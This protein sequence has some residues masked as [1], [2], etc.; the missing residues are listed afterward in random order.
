MHILLSILNLKL[1]AYSH[2][3]LIEIKTK[4]CNLIKHLIPLTLLSLIYYMDK[5]CACSHFTGKSTFNTVINKRSEMNTFPCIYS[6]N[7][8]ISR[9]EIL[10]YLF[11]SFIFKLFVFVAILCLQIQQFQI[12]CA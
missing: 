2:V 9:S 12:V 5:R 1:L 8:S 7:T 11:I 6:K 10:F 3:A 4:N